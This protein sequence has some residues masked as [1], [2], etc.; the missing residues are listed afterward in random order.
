M[1]AWTR[2][3]CVALALALVSLVLAPLQILA[4][5]C[6]W[7]L[8]RRLP[9]LW[10]RL[11]CRLI[12]LRVVTRGVPCAARPLLLV[13]NHQS[14]ADILALGQVAEVSFIAKAEVRSWPVFGWLAV[15]QRT[16]FVAREERGRT[17]EQADAI[18]ER[19]SEG[20]A[21][22]LFAE[23]T[24]SDGNGL[25]PFKTALFGAA[26]A[27]I[28]RSGAAEVAVQPVAVAYT[29]LHGMPMGRYFRPLAAWPGDVTLGPHLLA[30]LKEGAIDVEVSFGEPIAFSAASDRKTVG[31]RTEAEVRRLLAESLAGRAGS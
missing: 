25:L 21:M 20:D 15:L 31:R 28:R 10:H 27:A 26:Q 29:R 4:L 17:A 2:I 13:A 23:G 3:V 19:L 18:A 1:I 16:V 8:A 7:R 22:V 6:R 30:F 12:G 14:W 11:A 5:R 9:I 24:T